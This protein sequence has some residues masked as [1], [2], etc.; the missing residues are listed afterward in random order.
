MSP[1]AHDWVQNLSLNQQFCWH[2][3]QHKSAR[4]CL[5]SLLIGAN[6]QSSFPLA[7]CRHIASVFHVIFIM[8]S[9]LSACWEVYGHI[10]GPKHPLPVKIIQTTIFQVYLHK[11]RAATVKFLIPKQWRCPRYREWPVAGASVGEGVTSGML[12][13]FVNKL[14]VVVT[15]WDPEPCRWLAQSWVLKSW[16]WLERGWDSKRSL[17]RRRWLVVPEAMEA[18]EAKWDSNPSL[19]RLM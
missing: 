2:K 3:S 18:V 4:I 1:K 8:F 14:D 17:I 10:F 15:G 5:A 7:F 6:G 16:R 13:A 11:L 19:R 12:E 9:V